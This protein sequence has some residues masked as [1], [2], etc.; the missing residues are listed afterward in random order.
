MKIISTNP[1]KNY[2]VLGEVEVSTLEDVKKKV[3]AAKEASR[4]WQALGVEGR[5]PLIKKVVDSFEKDKEL[6]ARLISQEMGKPIKHAREEIDFGVNYFRSYLENAKQYLKSETTHQDEKE[7]H[8]VHQEPFGVAAVIVAW[9]YPFSNFVWQTGQNLVA[10]NTI[11]FKISEE[12]PLFGKA[13]EERMVKHL[14]KG[15]FNEVYGDKS[16]GE[17]LI[18]QEVNLICFTGSSQAG[19]KINQNAAGRFIKTNMELGGSA[20]GII[21]EDADIDAIIPTL[22]FRRFSNSGQMCDALKRLIVHESKVEEVIAKLTHH[23]KELHLGDAEDEKADLGPLVAERQL[24]L[25]KQ[26]L[27][28]ALQ[29]GAKVIVGGKEP[30]HLKGAYFEPTLLRNIQKNMRVWQEEVFGP[31][32]PIITFKEEAEAVALANDTKYGLGASIYTKDP[33][34]F[35]RVARQMESG[36][37]CQNGVSY[38]YAFNPFGGYKMS[39]GGREHAQFGFREVTQVKV[40]SRES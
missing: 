8:E 32:L 22:I 34:R 18:N 12:T 16:V 24:V 15:V 38:V 13:I 11:V 5:I 25:I 23:L 33:K 29:K 20:P 26:Q 4:E 39:G 10:G 2:Q 14:P 7:V 31:V 9:N 28:D 1:S 17:M 37:V 3:Q 35:S 19:A 27:D 40:V 36:M 21:F 30:A 6:L